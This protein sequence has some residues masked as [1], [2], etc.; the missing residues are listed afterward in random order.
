MNGARIRPATSSRMSVQQL[1]T[2]T[3]K[4]ATRRGIRKNTLDE[5][6]D[7]RPA[8]STRLK[9]SEEPAPEDERRGGGANAQDH[10][11]AANPYW[12]KRALAN[13]A[14]DQR[15]QGI[16]KSHAQV[17]RKNVVLSGPRE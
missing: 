17:P 2:N 6:S 7:R 11:H 14:H 13:G 12:R 1:A 4:Y 3:T 16:M 10:E 8:V 5:F 9:A 15:R